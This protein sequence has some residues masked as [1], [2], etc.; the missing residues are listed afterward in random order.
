MKLMVDVRSMQQPQ[1]PPRP[2]PEKG[3]GLTSMEP[4]SDD[5]AWAPAR[6]GF[7]RSAGDASYLSFTTKNVSPDEV[8]LCRRDPGPMLGEKPRSHCQ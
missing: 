5:A 2:F 4:W 3:A 8:A 6:A 7:A 1:P